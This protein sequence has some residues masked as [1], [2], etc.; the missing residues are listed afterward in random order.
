L[1]TAGG[2]KTRLEG[3]LTAA[4]TPACAGLGENTRDQ[5]TLTIAPDVVLSIPGI[6]YGKR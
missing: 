3:S 6:L 1:H 5:Q 4:E 2:L